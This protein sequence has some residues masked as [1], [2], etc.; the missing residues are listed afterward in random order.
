MYATVSRENIF[1]DTISLY[2]KRN[3]AT[4]QLQLPFDNEETSGDGV[5]RDAFQP[6]F[7]SVYSKMDGSNERVQ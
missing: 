3:A 5:T 4:H 6:F 7:A 1:H 2:K